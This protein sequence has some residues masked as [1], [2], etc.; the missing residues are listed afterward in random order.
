[1]AGQQEKVTPK[2]SRMIQWDMAVHA[3][4]L[5][6][7]GASVMGIANIMKVKRGTVSS[8]LDWYA[9]VQRHFIKR[10]KWQHIQIQKH[11]EIVRSGWEEFQKTMSVTA[12]VGFLGKINAAIEAQNRI[13][14]LDRSGREYHEHMTLIINS[15][16]PRDPSLF[17]QTMQQRKSRIEDLM[18]ENGIGQLGE[19]G[20]GNSDD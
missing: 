15:N 1:M 9:R 3:N 7:R 12:R 2:R 18:R 8:F 16:V 14:G 10:Y 20:A 4:R 17:A 13:L 6:A 5:Y 11:E 19:E